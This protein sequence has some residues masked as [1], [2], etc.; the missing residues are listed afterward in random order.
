MRYRLHTW[1]GI[2][3]GTGYCLAAQAVM[4]SPTREQFSNIPERNVFGL[5]EGQPEQETAPKGPPPKITLTGITTLLG[6]KLA[7]MRAAIPA[8][9][10][11]AG[12]EKPLMLSEGQ[13]DGNI[14]VL[15]IDERAGSV[16]VDDAGEV[17]TL[18]FAKNGVKP[19]SPG[20]PSAVV[21]ASGV[22]TNNVLPSP[23]APGVNTRMRVMPMR[24][25]RTPLTGSATTPGA[26]EGAAPETSAANPAYATPGAVPATTPSAS[27]L[28]LTPTGRT[29]AAPEQGQ[30]SPEQLAV[31]QAVAQA[32][33]ETNA[34]PP[35]PAPPTRSLSPY[36]LVPQGANQQSQRPPFYPQ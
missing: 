17:M 23:Y 4:P 11:T 7:L 30:L 36:P 1:L 18:T 29:N 20:G 32:A 10:G 31:L 34:P 26:T 22:R 27:D 12:Q 21:N 16:R 25:P 14:E 2:L 35:P 19:S 8:A 5:K 33:A 28:A 13:R 3:V 24:M 15:E 9:P 6:N